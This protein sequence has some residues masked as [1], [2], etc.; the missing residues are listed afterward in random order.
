MKQN[1]LPWVKFVLGVIN[2]EGR[3][4]DKLDTIEAYALEQNDEWNERI[5]AHIRTIEEWENEHLGEIDN[6]L[7]GFSQETTTETK[8]A[9][10]GAS[11]EVNNET[12]I[13]KTRPKRDNPSG[14]SRNNQRQPRNKPNRHRLENTQITNDNI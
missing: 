13:S 9:L 12:G 14:R 5:E 4:N 11:D 3:A 10:G 8:D 2:D 6:F 1:I 7:K